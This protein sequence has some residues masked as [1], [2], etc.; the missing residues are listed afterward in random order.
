M[1][2]KGNTPCPFWLANYLFTKILCGM[3]CH[4]I[5]QKNNLKQISKINLPRQLGTITSS[6][7]KKICNFSSSS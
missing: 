6:N 2:F 1:D 3:L 7:D 5:R 4:I